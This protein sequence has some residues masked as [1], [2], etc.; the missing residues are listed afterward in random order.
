MTPE[1]FERLRAIFYQALSLPEG[2]RAA[3]I[4]AQTPGQEGVRAEMMALLKAQ[5]PGQV[6]A[7]LAPP[8]L[9]AAPTETRPPGPAQAETRVGIYKVLRELGRGGMGTVYLA[10]RSDDVFSKVVALKVISLSAAQGDFVER[11]KQERQILAGLDHVHIA[12]ILDGGNTEDGRPYY[13]M[14][15]VDGL[16]IDGYCDRAGAGVTARVQVFIQV[17]DA[18]DYLHS[19]AI[20]HRD[21]KPSNIM[22][23]ADG[24]VKLLDFGIAKVQTVGG[25]VAGHGDGQPTMMM[26]PGYASPEQIE[27]RTVTKSAD[28]YALGVILYK[29]LTGTAPFANRDGSPNLAAQLSGQT[30][31]PPSRNST[32]TEKRTT[33]NPAEIR[34]RVG[35]DLD[36]VVLMA[37][38]RDPAQRYETVRQFGEDLRR[39]LDG[40]PVMAR[41]AGPLYRLSKFVGRNKIV[42]TLAALLA[43]VSCAGAWIAI[44]SRIQKARVEAREEALERFV[45]LLN[46]RVDHWNENADANGQNREIAD[47]QS[48]SQVLATEIPGVLASPAADPARVK[49]VIVGV[50]HF[51]ERADQ[52]SQGEAPVRKKIAVVYRQVGD[53]EATARTPRVSDKRDAVTE[54]KEAAAVAASVRPADQS[55]ANDQLA[56]L[57]GRLGTLGSRVDTNLLTPE[58]ATPLEQPAAA[59]PARTARHSAAPTALPPIAPPPAPPQPTVDAARLADIMQQLTITEA[60]AAQAHKN[61]EALRKRLAGDGQTVNQTTTAS[62][63]R[64]DSFLH[65]ARAA[66]GRQDLDAADDQRQKAEYEVQKVFRDV[67]N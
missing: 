5:D 63:A 38:E 6:S 39:F 22:V 49:N 14:E 55:W 48:A 4:E 53:L 26:T 54:Y 42:V 33:G 47:V 66:L 12:R 56:Q 25:L 61:L 51:L 1:Q 18:V 13:V 67:G 50:H 44:Q 32:I 58:Q 15:Y 37:L 10:V 62:M 45:N 28:I 34:R 16:P 30:P 9:S 52:K 17:C 24:Q 60:H 31:P 59:A 11:F 3:Y 41:H 36:R 29:L 35:G 2:D 43:V 19:Q 20:V 8:P 65:G 23:T 27:G 7:P 21:L 46:T 40:R 64:A 57:D